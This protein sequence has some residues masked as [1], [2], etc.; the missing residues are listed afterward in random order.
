MRG[1]VAEGVRLI[2]VSVGGSEKAG[3]GEGDIRLK[4]RAVAAC[5]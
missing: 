5:Y 1:W 3:G 2:A 4:K